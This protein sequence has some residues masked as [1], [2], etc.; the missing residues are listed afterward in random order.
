MDLKPGTRLASAV[1]E[2]EVVVVKAPAADVD[3]RCGGSRWSQ[4]GLRPGRRRSDARRA[5]R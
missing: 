2:T 3:L 1:C 4:G 5:A